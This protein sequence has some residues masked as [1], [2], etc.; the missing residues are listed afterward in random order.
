MIAV[1]F[2]LMAMFLV[3]RFNLTGDVAAR[4]TVVLNEYFNNAYITRGNDNETV[5]KCMTCHGKVGK[6]DNTGGKMS[7]AP[8]HTESPGHKIFSDAHYK[9]IQLFEK[10]KL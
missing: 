4:I 1:F 9:L 5:G 2:V 8:C 7:C 6:L 3:R 10:I